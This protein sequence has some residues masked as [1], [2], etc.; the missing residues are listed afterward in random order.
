MENIQEI[1]TGSRVEES[2]S[3]AIEEVTPRDWAKN[4]YQPDVVNNSEKLYKKLGYTM[5]NGIK[6]GMRYLD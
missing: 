5:L 2:V 6:E 3:V 4:V 1:P